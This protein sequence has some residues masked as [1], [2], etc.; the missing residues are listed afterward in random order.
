MELK[1]FYKLKSQYEYIIKIFME[2]CKVDWKKNQWIKLSVLID[3]KKWN[4]HK[5]VNC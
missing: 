4:I 2:K 3:L 1:F 5:K